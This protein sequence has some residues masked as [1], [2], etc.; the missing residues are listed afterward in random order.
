MRAKPQINE[1]SKKLLEASKRADYVN[2][3]VEDRLRLY[4]IHLNE[5]K[6]K[7]AL[8]EMNRYYESQ[9]AL[10]AYGG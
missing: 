6:S 9:R 4:G 3:K 8:D 2:L 7:Q 5:S 10:H 1:N